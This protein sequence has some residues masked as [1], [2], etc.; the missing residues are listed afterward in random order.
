MHFFFDITFGHSETEPVTA[1]EN[2]SASKENLFF[3]LIL[4]FQYPL[5]AL[6]Q[7]IKSYQLSGPIFA[8]NLF[9]ARPARENQ[10][11]NS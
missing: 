9:S 7:L 5:G 3:L 4:A 8:G 1:T 6:S 11:Q 10:F 2:N